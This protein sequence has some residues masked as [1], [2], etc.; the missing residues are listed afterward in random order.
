MFSLD[1]H[2]HSFFSDGRQ[3]QEEII[4]QAIRNGF[5][6]IGISDHVSV[7]P[8]HW[9]CKPSAYRDMKESF[10]RLK[11]KYKDKI[12]VKFGLEM[13]YIEGQESEIEK[14]I[15]YFSPDYVI[16]SVH[17]IGD[18]NFDTDKSGYANWNVDRL[19]AEYYR[20]IGKA[21]G[22]GLFDIIGHVDLI[23]KFN[24]GKPATPCENLD[25]AI[26]IIAKAG[27]SI[28]LNT[29]GMRKPCAEFYPSDAL[30]RKCIGASIPLT[31]GSDAH[32]SQDQGQF[33]EQA[34][35]LLLSMSCREVVSFTNRQTNRVLI[36]N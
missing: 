6:E 11:E 25:A 30:L 23:K 27:I 8:V 22:C 1:Y 29:S 16:G 3:S 34:V 33:F 5:D 35:A 10:P 19:Y 20:L 7:K 32:C 17:F 12:W 36:G 26:E 9:A 2:T 13:D 24:P 18:W 14:L 28:E 15:Q 4:E 21:A 31:I